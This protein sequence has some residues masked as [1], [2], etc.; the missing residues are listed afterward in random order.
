MRFYAEM[1]GDSLT[2]QCR[3]RYNG[4]KIEEETI[5]HLK[6][7]DGSRAEVMEGQLI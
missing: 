7:G 1:A 6:N 4:S 5:L 2:G 3:Y